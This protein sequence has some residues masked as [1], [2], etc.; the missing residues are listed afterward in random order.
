MLNKDANLESTKSEG[1]AKTED[2]QYGQ[3]NEQ[4]QKHEKVIA[5]K[6]KAKEMEKENQGDKTAEQNKNHKNISKTSKLET[7][8]IK[9]NKI[10][11]GKFRRQKK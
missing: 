3:P 1:E 4:C 7:K 9:S 11:S 10:T 5:D 6:T 2:E 8:L